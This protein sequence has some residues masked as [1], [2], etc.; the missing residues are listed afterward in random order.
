MGNSSALLVNHLR[1]SDCISY[2]VLS[3]MEMEI[4]LA[5]LY[6]QEQFSDD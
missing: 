1:G 3:S 4:T 2:I 5:D 6:G